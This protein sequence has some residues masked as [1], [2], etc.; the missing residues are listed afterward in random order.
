MI[1]NSRRR[2]QA[3]GQ[4]NEDYDVLYG[5]LEDMRE[6]VFDLN[7]EA[8]IAM[9]EKNDVVEA[10]DIAISERN[11]LR[12]RVAE[13][14]HQNFQVVVTPEELKIRDKEAPDKIHS[15]PVTPKPKNWHRHYRKTAA[16]EPAETLVT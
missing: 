12:Q 13:T 4:L 14:E 7:D 2:G 5:R 1:I 11:K 6:K 10:L 9:E 8:R 16:T 3:I 15:L